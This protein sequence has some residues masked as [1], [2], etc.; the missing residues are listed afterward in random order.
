MTKCCPQIELPADGSSK[1]GDSR[2]AD[3]QYEQRDG[4]TGSVSSN[5]PRAAASPV[6]GRQMSVHDLTPRQVDSSH[7]VVRSSDD[8]IGLLFSAAEEVDS[9]KEHGEGHDQSNR[10]GQFIGGSPFSTWSSNAVS[11]GKTKLCHAS[12]ENIAHWSQHRFVRQ[13]WFSAREAITYIDL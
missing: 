2:L 3:E 7:L 10:P 5:D 11:P 9:E 13:G 8:A 1:N 6:D 12:A 4:I